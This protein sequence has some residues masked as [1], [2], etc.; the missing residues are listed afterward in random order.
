M[1]GRVGGVSQSLLHRPCRWLTK[2][3]VAS[4]WQKRTGL[5]VAGGGEGRQHQT[6]YCQWI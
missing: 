1:K 2:G 5:R 6:K 4:R 3:Y